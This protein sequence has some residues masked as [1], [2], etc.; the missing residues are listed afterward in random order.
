MTV[1]ETIRA[2][3]LSGELASGDWLKDSVL[4]TELG[5]SRAPVREALERLV[6]S[7]LVTK[8]LNRPYRVVTIDAAALSELRLLRF[9]DESAAIIHVVL[10]CTPLAA[11][12]A[13][14]A[15]MERLTVA[16][17]GWVSLVDVD[18][19]FHRALVAAT[20]LPR[21]LSRFDGITDQIR[22]WLGGIEVPP[23]VAGTQLQRHVELRDTL[24]ACQAAQ[25][26]RPAIRLWEAH[27]LGDHR[28]SAFWG[29]ESR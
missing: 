26:V 20:G 6:Q 13:P 25:D 27:L 17:A 15:E 14:L 12:E 23:I 2:R 21:L 4:A 10:N 11:L 3:I 18:L 9:A 29:D 24:V 7:G 22:A 1:L 5:T 19:E 28:A 16:G 8:T